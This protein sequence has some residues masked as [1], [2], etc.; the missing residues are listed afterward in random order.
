MADQAGAAVAP[1]REPLALTRVGTHLE[2]EPQ[3]ADSDACPCLKYRCFQAN[4]AVDPLRIL[5]VDDNLVNLKVAEQQLQK[6]GYRVDLAG[7]GKAAIEALFNTHYTVVLLD[8]EMP[9]MDGYAHRC[10]NPPAR[11]Q[12]PPHDRSR[13]DGARPRGRA[14]AM[15]RRRHGRI[16]RQAGYSA[17]LDRGPRTLC[18]AGDKRGWLAAV[19]KGLAAGRRKVSQ[20]PASLH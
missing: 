19:G 10:G 16:R 15:P 1:A 17:S 7:G 11:R 2:A 4:R 18:L 14:P 12:P 13:D 9:E 20:R 5:V 3:P 6:L 8:C